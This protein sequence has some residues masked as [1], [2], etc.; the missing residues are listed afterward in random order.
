[1]IYSQKS[2][3]HHITLLGIGLEYTSHQRSAPFGVGLGL[4]LGLRIRIKVW[5]K[6]SGLGLG[7]RVSV[8]VNSK[9]NSVCS[10]L[11]RL[12]LGIFLSTGNGS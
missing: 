10:K 11:T 3:L 4:G 1:M 5:V 9:P 12:I 6:V 8:V 2:P 7:I